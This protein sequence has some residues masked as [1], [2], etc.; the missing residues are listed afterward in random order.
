M[1]GIQ[2]TRHQTG[3][4]GW[5]AAS[6]GNILWD[7]RDGIHVNITLSRLERQKKIK[8]YW[9]DGKAKRSTCQSA[10]DRLTEW[11]LEQISDTEITLKIVSS[12]WLAR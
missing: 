11:E 2:I 8:L 12:L 7:K 10:A 3:S 4:E 1:H 9:Q 6:S 5:P